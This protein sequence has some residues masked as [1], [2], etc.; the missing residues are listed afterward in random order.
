MT[1]AT[2][3]SGHQITLSAASAGT[4]S[5]MLSAEFRFATEKSQAGQP[6]KEPGDF[7]A[8]SRTD[9]GITLLLSLGK[10]EK[11]SPEIARRAGGVLGKWLK[12]SGAALL[13][14]DLDLLPVTDENAMIS[15]A[16]CEGIRLGGYEFQRYKK[17]TEDPR[18]IIVR[19]FGKN[20]QVAEKAQIITEAVLYA[21]DL[22]HEPANVI[23][24]TSLANTAHEFAQKFGLQSRII[25]EKELR[26]LGAGAILA[27][28]SGSKTPPCLIILEYKGDGAG[29]GE[30]PVV[31]VGKA[32]TFDSGGYSIK[33]AN[34]MVGMKYDK[35][36]GV[37]VMATVG[38]AAAQKMKTPVV[39]I[40]GAAENMISNEA[41]RPDDILTTL[42]GKTVEIISTD[43]EGRLV[44][45]D[46]LA[47]AQQAYQPRTLID[48]ATLT[49]GVVAALGHV[50]AGLL[51]N[52]DSLANALSSSGDT[53]FERVWRL[54]LDEEFTKNM[55]GDDADLKNSGG[56]EGACVLGG[57]FLQEFIEPGVAWAHIDIAG[58]ATTSKDLPYAPKG[59]TGFGIRLLIDY[60]EK[61]A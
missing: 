33:E 34:G 14:I 58:M 40:I 29:T 53:T 10:E 8:V 9:G 54:P 20:R 5:A 55:Q 13:D 60:L 41:Y 6:G 18:N 48:L 38:A 26:E 56:R 52:N 15:Q 30:K 59:A 44:L 16:I 43:A 46:A 61:L 7:I 21:R 31:L 12:K 51:S 35:C 27:V 42:N 50:R 1:E 39:G 57:A 22:S 47:Y 49:G 36:G 2:S 24:P 3:S 17:Q 32:I 25:D 37:A 28:G 23:N 11:F 45:A 4:T 19:L